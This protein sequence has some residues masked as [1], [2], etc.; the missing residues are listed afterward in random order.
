MKK[1]SIVSLL[2]V[3]FVLGAG[4]SS[5]QIA[6]NSSA[7]KSGFVERRSE[8]PPTPPENVPAPTPVQVGE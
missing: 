8:T 2:G 6:T 1:F 5:K 7:N 3:L 4:C